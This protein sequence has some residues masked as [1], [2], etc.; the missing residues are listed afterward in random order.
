MCDRPDCNEPIHHWFGLT[1]SSYLVLPRVGLQSMPEPW[2]RKLVAL[3]EEME[4]TIDTDEWPSEYTVQVRNPD[5]TFATADLPSYRH[6]RAEHRDPPPGCTCDRQGTTIRAF[7]KGCPHHGDPGTP[8]SSCETP[9]RADQGGKSVWDDE[10]G[11]Y[12]WF[13]A[14]CAVGF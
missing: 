3:L 7:N 11:R 5:G 14:D 1:Y 8:C 4:G 12:R 6:G 9:A 13:C 10:A 2:Q